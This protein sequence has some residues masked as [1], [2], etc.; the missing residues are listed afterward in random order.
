MIDSTTAY[1]GEGTA[2][3]VRRRARYDAWPL[4]GEE[5]PAEQVLA[6]L[7][8]VLGSPDFRASTR[9]RRAL[10]YLVRTKLEGRL[11]EL[12]AYHIATRAYGRPASFDPIKDPIVRIEMAGLR[13]HLEMY[14]LK[15]GARNPLRI[16]LPKGGYVVRVARAPQVAGGLMQRDPRVIMVLRAALCAWSGDREAAVS[17]W[18]DL[19]RADPLWPMNLQNCAAEALGDEK[20][21]RLVVEGALRAARWADSNGTAA[22]AAD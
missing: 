14:Y 21:V 3:P 1:I 13:R 22:S 4:P 17:A 2:A 15:S 6:E 11:E 19:K 18:Q 9:N 20:V 5:F 16:T 8:R 12:K 7:Q 10:E